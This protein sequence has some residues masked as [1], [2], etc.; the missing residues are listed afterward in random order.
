MLIRPPLAVSSTP[1]PAGPAARAWLATICAVCAFALLV[2]A[3]AVAGAQAGHRELG[4]GSQVG[5]TGVPGFAGDDRGVRAAASI[6]WG[7]HPVVSLVGWGALDTFPARSS[8]AGSVGIGASAALDAIAVVPFIA[9]V[10]TVQFVDGESFS[11]ATSPRMGLRGVLGAD[12]RRWRS[13]SIG[14]QIEW[15][16]YFPRALSYPAQSVVA[17]RATWYRDL[18]RW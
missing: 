15:H 9:L 8:R 3:P 10:P 13:W 11:G 17:L 18:R 2:V 5:Y 4:L 16:A 14:A 12:W 1:R 7:A 6:S